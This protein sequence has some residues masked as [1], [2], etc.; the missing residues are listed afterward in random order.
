MI[1]ILGDAHAGTGDGSQLIMRH[2]LKF[3]TNEFIPYLVD[4]G[5]DTVI[6]TGDIFD[7]RRNTNTDVLHR[8]KV[9]FFDVL[10]Q[11]N[12]K[13]I[14]YVGNHD[15]Y[16]KNRISPNTVVEH[17]S[18]YPNVTIIDKPTELVVDGTSMLFVPWIC[19][20]NEADCHNAIKNS[21]SD[22]CF[23]HFEIKG[24][25]MES[26]ICEEGL[27]IS[28]FKHFKH[29]ISGHFHIEGRYENV[30]YVGTP[31]EM[32]WNDYGVRKGFWTLDGNDMS[33][34]E[35]HNHIFNRITYNESV[36][37]M[38]QLTERDISDCYIKVVID[39]RDDFKVYER[40]QHKLESLGPAKLDIIEPIMNRDADESEV[41]V[42]GELQI[43][44][45]E[46]IIREYSADLY[47]ERSESL[48]KMMLNI[49]SEARKTYGV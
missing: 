44:S 45:T 30:R 41:I 35:N 9:E 17:L 2:Q 29:C 32:S 31:Y 14:V 11:Y 22:I 6:Q 24:A 10:K 48:S 5:I 49:H 42:D 23:G 21:T 1:A 16:Y 39:E 19:E 18:S 12:I 43:E 4:N 38:S 27:A 8:W 7:V 28:E 47:P 40:W 36:D 46:D 33:F 15:M 20:E 37:M 3:L 26:S 13:L 34:I 25:R